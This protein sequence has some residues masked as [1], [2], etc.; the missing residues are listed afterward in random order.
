V[1]TLWA[2][3]KE[4]GPVPFCD[5]SPREVPPYCLVFL[6]TSNTENRAAGESKI[7]LAPHCIL[8]RRFSIL[9]VA[10]SYLVSVYDIGDLRNCKKPFYAARRESRNVMSCHEL[11]SWYR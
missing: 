4:L 6:F 9:L 7:S 5:A 11:L 8:D 2:V 10:S 3:S 1:V